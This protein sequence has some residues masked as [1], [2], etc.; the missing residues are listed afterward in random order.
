VGVCGERGSFVLGCSGQNFLWAPG[1][2][3]QQDP[4]VCNKTFC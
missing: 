2:A 1:D 3:G 4:A